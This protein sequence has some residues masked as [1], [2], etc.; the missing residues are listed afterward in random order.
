ML[1]LCTSRAKYIQLDRSSL[2]QVCQRLGIWDEPAAGGNPFGSYFD[3]SLVRVLP[4]NQCG[5]IK[6]IRHVKTNGVGV[7]V[8]MERIGLR[9]QKRGPTLFGARD[10]QPSSG[11]GDGRFELPDSW[12]RPG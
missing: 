4:A 9:G 10:D 11:A 2:K 1:P 6:V 8:T 3:L 7:S 12:D 5:V